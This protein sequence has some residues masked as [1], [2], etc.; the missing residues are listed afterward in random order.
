M[1]STC[2]PPTISPFFFNRYIELFPFLGISLCL[3]ALTDYIIWKKS[4]S[5]GTFKYYLLNQ[6]ISAQILEVLI[7]F[8]NPVLLTPYNAGL[9]AGIVD[10]FAS[11][12]TCVYGLAIGVCFFI[13]VISSVFIT[14]TNRFIFMFYPD[15]RRY[16]ENKYTMSGIVIFHFVMYSFAFGIMISTMTS[17]NQTRFEA[18]RDHPGAMEEYFKFNSFA[19]ISGGELRYFL[20]RIGLGVAGCLV[21]LL[22]ISVT[23]F[24]VNVFIYKK[25]ATVISKTSKFLIVSSILQAL[26]CIVFLMFPLMADS[27]VTTETLP[28]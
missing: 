18:A 27:Y 15:S 26:I 19:Y 20:L 11:Y 5:L 13:N 22:L 4:D 1:P 10:N 25:T 9:A 8:V 28:E 16:L 21:L 23:F 17:H 14:L 2:P 3:A 6:A 12:N 24:I 7:I